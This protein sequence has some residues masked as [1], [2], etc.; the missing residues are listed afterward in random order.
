[1]DLCAEMLTRHLERDFAG[2]L[3]LIDLCPPF[4]RRFAR[5]P[6]VGERRG[7][8][9][10]RLVNRFWDYPCAAARRRAEADVFHLVDHSYSQIISK[11]P[12]ERT[13]VY[14]HDLDTFRC[15]LTPELEPRPLLFR[16]MARRILTGFQKAAVVF[17]SN[18]TVCEQIVAHGLIDPARLIHAPLGFAEEFRLDPPDDPDAA[19]IRARIGN[20]PYLLHVGSCIPRKRIDV[21]LAVFARL[22]DVAPDLRLVKIGGEWTGE[23]SRQLDELKIRDRVVHI[24]NAGRPTLASLYRDAAIVMLPS[25]A[26]GFGLPLLEALACGARVLVSDL[27]VF[28]GIAGPV[29]RYA[30]VGKVDEFVDIARELLQSV[31]DDAVRSKRASRVSGYSWRRHAEIIGETYLRLG[32]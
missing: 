10:D 9:A 15:L 11:L 30:G 18:A 19:A 20:R 14:C 12:G 26:E 31:D 28:R 25:D 6:L 1:M 4:R 5:L 16:R 3:S 32:S 7:F 21:L 17:Y 23:Q 13:G 22:A 2:R 8:T 27:A 29:A 24:V